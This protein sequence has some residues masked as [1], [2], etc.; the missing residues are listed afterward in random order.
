LP[1][2]Y[3]AKIVTSTVNGGVRTEFP[4]AL[5]GDLH[6]Q[7]NLEFNVGSGGPPIRIITRNGGVSIRKKAI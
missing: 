7:K 3:S 4:V 5:S 1:M 2:N 6:R